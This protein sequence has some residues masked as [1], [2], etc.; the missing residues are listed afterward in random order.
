MA[1]PKRRAAPDLEDLRCFADGGALAKHS[2]LAKPLAPA[3]AGPRREALCVE[4][5]RKLFVGEAEAEPEEHEIRESLDR[6]MQDTPRG[7][8]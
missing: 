4:C 7:A 3:S 8:P 5:T 1:P 2:R 6:I